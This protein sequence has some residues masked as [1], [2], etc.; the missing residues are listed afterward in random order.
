MPSVPLD[1]DW[2]YQWVLAKFGH[3]SIEKLN[4]Q[5][6]FYVGNL[7]LFWI[8]CHL[9]KSQFKYFVVVEDLP[10]RFWSKTRLSQFRKEQGRFIQSMTEQ[11]SLVIS[12]LVQ[13]RSIADRLRWSSTWTIEA[14][15]K[16]TGRSS[17]R[18][19]YRYK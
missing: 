9:H 18:L 17:T 13:S 6:S 7:A 10:E 15:F 8:W 2:D 3:N 14:E 4:F 5:T 19:S 11:T 1:I 12:K 16:W